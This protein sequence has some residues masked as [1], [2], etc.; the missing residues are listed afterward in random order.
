MAHKSHKISAQVVSMDEVIKALLDESKPFSPRYLHSFSD[1]SPEDLEK[2]SEIWLSIT[3]TRRLAILEDLEELYDSDTVVSFDD[4]AKMA[5]LDPSGKVRVIAIHLL[6][7][8]TK[9]AFAEILMGM[10]EEDSDESVRAAAASALGKF[11]ELFE[12]ED[13]PTEVGR[14]VVAALLDK[15]SSPDTPNVRRYALEALGWSSLPE[16]A[17]LIQTA[18][19]SGEER[20]VSSAL[21]AMGVSGMER[22]EKPVLKSLKSTTP[23][24]LHEAVVA[25]GRLHL[26]EARKW[27]F[28]LLDQAPEDSEIRDDILWALAQIGGEGVRELLETELESAENDESV[29]FLTELLDDLDFNEGESLPE[30]F[31]L[32][33]DEDEDFDE[34][35]VDGSDDEFDDDDDVTRSME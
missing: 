2:L 32:S 31:A 6:P 3:D 23:Q 35:E 9:P 28:K 5:L 33:G 7:E 24:I 4:V 11:V 13:I 26:E 25:S 20:W 10:M 21:F 29:E 30:L 27:L 8:Y 19:E 17:P 15:V 16:V 1:I 34:D 22:W 14:G 12:L 18:F